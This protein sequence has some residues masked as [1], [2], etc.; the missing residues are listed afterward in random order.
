MRKLHGPA[1]SPFVRKAWIFLKEKSIDFEHRQ[2]D[3]LDKS[4]RFLKMNPLGRVP[5]LEEDDGHLIPDSSVI[6]EYL[7]RTHPAP[8]LYPSEHRARA[9][10]MWLEEYGDTLLVGVCARVFWMHVIIPIRTGKPVD[11][12]EVAK[13]VDDN[14]PGAFNHLESISPSH[15]H[16][17]GDHFGIADISLLSPVRLLDLAGAPLD[18]NRWPKFEA[19]YRRAIDRPSVRSIVDAEV[20]ATEVFRTTGNAPK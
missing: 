19:W 17:M 16:M 9:H 5:I 10:A 15:G 4:A 18:A 20:A 1:T 14:F 13:F 2:L 8:A 6:C 12:N 7:E 3:P 11:L